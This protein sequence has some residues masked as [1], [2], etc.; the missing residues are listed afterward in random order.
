MTRSIMINL[1]MFSI[2]MPEIKK[3]NTPPNIN[4]IM[5]G[6]ITEANLIPPPKVLGD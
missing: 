2:N 1:T 4:E 5:I 6:I 3:Y